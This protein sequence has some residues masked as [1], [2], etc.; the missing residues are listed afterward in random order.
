MKIASERVVDLALEFSES[1]GQWSGFM[2]YDEDLFN[3]ATIERIVGHI[4]TVLT[5]VTDTPDLRVAQIPMLTTAEHHQLDI[6]N[7]T[8]IEA[9]DETV[10][11]A[12][13]RISQRQ[14]HSPAL[15]GP[16]GTTTTY[17]QLDQASARIATH[18]CNAGIGPESVVGICL[19]RSADIAIAILGVLRS[20][21]AYLP[22]D[23]EQPASRLTTMVT[24]ADA[25]ALVIHQATKHLVP[26]LLTNRPNVHLIDLEYPIDPT[27]TEPPPPSPHHL[28][29]IIYTSGS[30]GTP[31]G[32]E[33]EHG[34]LMNLV[35]WETSVTPAARML[36]YAS[37]GFDVSV[38]EIFSMLCSGGTAIIASENARHDPDDL[39]DLLVRYEV[40]SIMLPPTMLLALASS[41]LH[42]DLRPPLRWI[43]ATGERLVVD[44]N[45]RRWVAGL[46]GARLANHYGPSEAH[47]VS[48]ELLP[49]DPG[50]WPITPRVG[51][52]IWNARLEIV[53]SWGE[54]AGIGATGELT[55]S[56]ETL[57]RGY[58]G[59]ADLT[60][61]RFRPDP[62]G[63]PGSR[64]YRIGDL[65]RR[66]ASGSLEFLGR[67][68]DQVK[69]R[70]IRVEPGE[71]TA[72]L[73]EHPS[74]KDAV[75]RNVNCG[76]EPLLVAF[77]VVG[78]STAAELSA[79]LRQHLPTPMVP[80]RI[81]I[82]PVLHRT[83]NGKLD[84]NR[85]PESGK[86]GDLGSLPIKPASRTER[87]LL[88]IWEGVLQVKGIG[89]E[90]NFFDV[91]GNSLNALAIRRRI[92][93]LLDRSVPVVTLFTFPSI[94][95]LAAALASESDQIR[96]EPSQ[97]L[98]LRSGRLARARKRTS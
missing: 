26:Q 86:L 14:P 64:R 40:D 88:E 79:Y 34:P 42:L 23:P 31:K 8:T 36:Q 10:I 75:V 47:R 57:A 98:S 20:G 28:A 97:G 45:L 19:Q 72:K 22:L 54:R 33:M 6:W 12:F 11:D 43:G 85:L 66:T 1:G 62:L 38:E 51:Q 15:I 68:D 49:E 80:S 52:P 77:V 60:A 3:R 82:V 53:D 13:L 84:L 58:H 48:T 9:P 39:A 91:G 55:V 50:T 87:D 74:V 93:D 5:A 83:A 90:D 63:P 25:A 27:T 29:Y 21:A 94:R 71:I 7:N 46:D 30:T 92:A 76:D 2:G 41:S 44:T 56:G 78:N 81:V 65:A 61:D 35:R 24:D 18:L 96:P 95:S 73:L 70:G 89:V 4:K 17:E 16:D 59:R 32:I 37:I 67:L 69:I